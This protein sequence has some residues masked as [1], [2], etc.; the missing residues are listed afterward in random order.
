MAD[1]ASTA[2]IDHSVWDRFLHKYAHLGTDGIVRVAYGQVGAAE[3][4]EIDADLVRLA[5]L[6]IS[7]FNRTE[8]LA[9]WINL[10][11]ELTVK[12]VLDHYPIPSIKDT[13]ALL[14]MF[15]STPW[16]RKL[17]KVEGEDLTLDDIEHRIL[18]PGWSD[19]R[20]HYTLN[21]ASMGCPNLQPVAYTA[22]NV[23]AMLDSA[24]R[25]Y[26]NS[27][28]GAHVEGG[29]LTVSSIYV[30]YKKD[31]GGTD[32]AVIA[33]LKLYAGAALQQALNGVD[34]IS[35]DYYDWSLNE[36]PAH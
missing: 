27:P 14:K 9:Y 19:P 6:P 11:N 35:R 18:R 15:S 23:G 22:A 26:V 10:Y 21:C 30:W 3:K 24:A 28:R 29:K 13:G 5:A 17:T 31:F 20:I 12:F 4:A 16:S 2:S 1:A 7:H 33:H 32:A 36:Y 34:K 8:Q 25:Q